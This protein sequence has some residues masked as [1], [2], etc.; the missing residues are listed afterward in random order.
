[1]RAILTVIGKDKRGIISKVTT[2]LNGISGN[3]E[4]ISQTLLQDYFVMIMLVDMSK[5]EKKL[6]DINNDLDKM[7]EEL[8]VSIRMQREEIFQAMHR[9]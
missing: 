8:G 9:I 7:S 4:D 5:S 1:M 2:Y 6:A 3:I